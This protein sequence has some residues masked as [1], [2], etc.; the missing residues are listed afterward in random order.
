MLRGEDMKAKSDTE[1]K[2]KT[3]AEI[4]QTLRR[5]MASVE[6]ALAIKDD[7]P[8]NY[9]LITKSASWKG[10]PMFFGAVMRKSYVTYHLM[11]LYWKPALVDLLSPALR[12]RMQG[13][14]CFNFKKADPVLFEELSALTK[15]CLESY[16]EAKLL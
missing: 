16:R 13:K 10:G 6:P 7:A 2:E 4:F 5:I 3:D 12:K 1:A 9:S 8:A 15:T 14:S 11:P